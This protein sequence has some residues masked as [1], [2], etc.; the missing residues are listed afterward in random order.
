MGKLLQRILWFL[1]DLIIFRI[2]DLVYV[3]ELHDQELE[4]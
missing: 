3:K 1:E 4:D 2:L